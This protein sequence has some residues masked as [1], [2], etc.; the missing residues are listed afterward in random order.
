MPIC[1]ACLSDNTNLLGVRCFLKKYNANIYGCMYCNLVF[2]ENP[3]WLDEAY[4]ISY[5]EDIDTGRYWRNNIICS[6]ISNIYNNGI[7]TLIDIGSGSEKILENRIKKSIPN[8]NVTSYDKYFNSDIS[9]LNSKYNILTAIEVVEHIPPKEFWDTY[10]DKANEFI[11][12]TGIHDDVADVLDW[13]YF[14]R[15]YGQH[16]NLYSTKT[17]HYIANKYNMCV[18]IT[19]NSGLNII[20]YIKK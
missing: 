3:H 18:S 19:K 12:T 5:N 10:I 4:S 15:D 17:I 13:G 7:Y 8:I 2:V 6:Y 1:T 11:I 20:H 14:A 16:I 9:K